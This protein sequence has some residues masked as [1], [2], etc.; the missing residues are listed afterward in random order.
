[1]KLLDQTG[2]PVPAGAVD[3]VRRM[4]W[5]GD[6]PYRAA[7]ARDQALSNWNP[8]GVS[9]DMASLIDRDRVIARVRDLIRNNGL[10]R[11]AVVK[12]A[13]M[14]V[15]QNW[16][17]V[18]L[19]DSMALGISREEAA[20]LGRRI[21]AVWRQWSSDPLRR[22]DRQR[23]H[24][25]PGLV[26]LMYREFRTA[27]EALGVL[28]SH[29]RSGWMFATALHLIDVDRLSN[30]RGRT[31]SASLRGGVHLDSAGEPLGYWIRNAHPIDVG[32]DA[33]RNSW[34]YVP[35]ETAWGRPVCVHGF[36]SERPGQ[37][38][39]VSPFAAVLAPF[40]MIDRHADAE[41]ASATANAL[42]IATITS[43]YDPNVV[44]E[45]FGGEALGE[46][47]SWQD[48]RMDI[49]EGAPIYLSGSRIPIL[50]P[51]D[52]IKMNN[53]P[54]QTAAFDSFRS[55]FIQEMASALDVPYVALAERWDKVN[56]S[57]ARAALNEVWR[58]IQARRASFIEQMITPIFLAVIEE[59]FANGMLE[60]PAGA[61]SFYEAQAAY[62][63]GMWVGP[64][65]GYIDP[66]KEQTAASMRVEDGMSTLQREC[67]EQGLDWEEVLDQRARELALQAELEVTT[68]AGDQSDRAAS[69]SYDADELDAAEERSTQED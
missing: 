1:M 43:G 17:L 51:G 36:E 20:E 29:R 33:K 4:A 61:P 23:R 53:A 64:G 9:A 62:L 26:N 7:S 25:F 47:N 54:R 65:R 3:A 8:S 59:A 32:H 13:D 45:S 57:S 38:R 21:E 35:K 46:T 69:A 22:C 39:G 55:S 58:S 10:A 27:G 15:G 48:T 2:A 66:V 6:R 52:E 56:Y 42:T 37:T 60:A 68:T 24:Q 11:A 50:P 31:E 34:T 16:R 67:A 18:S 63:K 12:Q 49:H 40:R 30:P 44:G 5:A 19:P 28:R 41:I 14:V